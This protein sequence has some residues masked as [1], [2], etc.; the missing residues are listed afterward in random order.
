MDP[1]SVASRLESALFQLQALGAQAMVSSAVPGDLVLV[2]EQAH[3][4]SV[5]SMIEALRKGLS[6]GKSGIW[7]MTTRLFSEK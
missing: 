4:V 6:Q 7:K 2:A 5:N 3:C 1:D